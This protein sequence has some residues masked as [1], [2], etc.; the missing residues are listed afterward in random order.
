MTNRT[1]QRKQH[2]SQAKQ[3]KGKG[4]GSKA[5]QRKRAAQ[6]SRFPLYAIG[7]V[8]VLVLA[9]VGLSLY[10]HAKT[11]STP[12]GTASAKVVDQLSERSGRARSTPP[13]PARD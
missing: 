2:P 1:A 9:M 3:G 10:N 4:K 6:R 12:G 11:P 7:A 13:A 8:I 5:Q